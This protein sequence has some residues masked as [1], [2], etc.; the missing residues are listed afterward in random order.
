[1]IQIDTLNKSFNSLNVLK[2]ISLDINRGEIFG[3][4]GK[5]GAGKSTLLRCINLL[6]EY[7]EGK[8]L[9]DGIEIKIESSGK[10]REHRKNMGMIFQHFSLLERQ[11]IYKNIA[12][13]ME[14]WGYSKEDI[15]KRVKELVKLVGI[16]DKLYEKPSQLSGGQKQRVAIARALALNPRI[17]LCDEATSAL[18]PKTTKSILA[19]L[20][21]INERLNITIVLVTHQMEV[22]RAICHRAAII[23]NGTIAACDE[24][25]N[26]FLDQPDCLKRLLGED[27]EVIIKKG[28]TIRI[29]FKDEDIRSNNTLSK[30]IKESKVDIYIIYSNL[31]KFRD[32]EIG[33][34]IINIHE[35]DFEVIK[36]YLCENHLKWEVTSNG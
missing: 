16:E 27:I 2:D 19:L 14:C 34:S 21:E 11:N 15:D 17:L 30:I 28:I 7:E 4:I 3:L 5:S 10:I 35:K 36:E 25:K 20:R 24:V 32:D 18:D 12:I 23:E 33:V 8:I 9:I 6:E 29:L 1:M 13:P 31:E 26:L 22:I